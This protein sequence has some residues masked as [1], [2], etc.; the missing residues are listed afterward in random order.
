ME[1]NGVP[2]EDTFAEAFDMAATRLIIT[3]RTTQWALHAAR[4]ATGFATSVI[5]CGLEAGIERSL[6]PAETPDGRPG[7]AVLFFG[8]DRDALVGQVPTRVGQCVMTCPT[9]AVFSG[10]EAEQALPVGQSLRYFGDGYQIAKR[11]GGSR[12]WRVPVM[13]GEFLCE[14]EA[15]VDRAIGGGNFLVLADS[16]DG[17]LQACE[18]AVAAIAELPNV[19][20]PFP[21]GVVRS[22]SKVGSKYSSLPASTNERYCPTLRGLTESALGPETRTVLEVVID[23]L[24]RADIERAMST[25]IGAACRSGVNLQ[26][27][28]AGNF[29]GTLGAH[30]FQLREIA[31]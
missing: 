22:G 3:A 6:D 16:E 8:F 4:T 28:S 30:H 11:L 1:L 14:E 27:I 17:A 10:L 24:S 29:G 20:T 31:A 15:G 23:G 13:D 5:G 26:Q 21:G 18:L 19:V 2:I 9:T 7:V 12:Y 25:G